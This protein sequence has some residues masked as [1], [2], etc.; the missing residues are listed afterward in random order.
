[1]LSFHD[2]FV[3]KDGRTTVKQY[4]P[5]LSIPGHKKLNFVLEKTLWEK[6]KMLVFQKSSYTGLLKVVFVW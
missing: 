3:Q 5:G 6:E 4:A 1:M 2:K